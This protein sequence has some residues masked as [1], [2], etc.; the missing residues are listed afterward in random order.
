MEVNNHPGK[1]KM[2]KKILIPL[3][4][5]PTDE[6]ILGHIRPKIKLLGSN[7]ILVHVADGYAARLQEELN[8]EDSEEIQ[9]DRTYLDQRKTELTSAGFQVETHLES[10]DPAEKI[11]AL[12]EQ[13]QCDLIAMATHGHRLLK[14]IVL[15]SVAEKLRHR[16]QIPILMIR[17]PIPDA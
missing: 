12:A 1:V 15:G 17:A 7:V 16:T 5:S 10:G 13:N 6:V 2:Y 3:E 14:D 9:K 4:N 8:L 11:I